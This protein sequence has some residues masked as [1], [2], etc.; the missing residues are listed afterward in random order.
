[1]Y[2]GQAMACSKLHTNT[3][4]L[5]REQRLF[6]TVGHVA[7]FHNLQMSSATSSAPPA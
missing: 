5:F 1:M 2:V 7:T 6:S 3:G 4:L